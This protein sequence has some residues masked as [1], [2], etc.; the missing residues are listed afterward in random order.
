MT[1]VQEGLAF[2]NAVDAAGLPVAEQA[3]CLRGLARA[4]SAHTAAQA[5][6]LG[7]FSAGGGYEDDGQ[8]SARVWLRWQTRITRGAAAGAVGWMRRL[9]AHPA[10]GEALAQ[11]AISPSW[12]REICRWSDALPAGHRADADV[13]F[14]A[15]AA[16]GA[17]LADLAGLAEEMRRRAAGPDGDGPDHFDE[18]QAAAGHRRSAGPAGWTGT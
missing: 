15:A 17:G 11:G 12:A 10:V 8:G 16:G 6:M 4:E 7:A 9:L 13:I 1:A 5:R 2:L 3:E 14:L 18:R